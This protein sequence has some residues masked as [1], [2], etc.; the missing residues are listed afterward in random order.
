MDHNEIREKK[1]K[2]RIYTL[3]TKFLSTAEWTDKQTQRHMC[4][5]TCA[6]ANMWS[7]AKEHNNIWKCVPLPQSLHCRLVR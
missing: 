2:H 5:W 3:T 6:F 4:T 1:R 7:V